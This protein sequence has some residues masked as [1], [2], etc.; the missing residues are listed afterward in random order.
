MSPAFYALDKSC[1][2]ARIGQR[3]S[4]RLA[5]SSLIPPNSFLPPRHSPDLP[6]RIKNNQ[7]WTPYDRSMFYTPLSD[8][9]YIDYAVYGERGHGEIAAEKKEQ[10]Q[11][12]Q[13]ANM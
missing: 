10:E 6:A 9:G 7:K 4:R 3:L 13:K 1:L 8:E 12:Q 2:E 11:E 5:A